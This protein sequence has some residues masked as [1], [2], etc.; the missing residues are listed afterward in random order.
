MHCE[1]YVSIVFNLKMSIVHCSH[2]HRISWWRYR[3]RVLLFRSRKLFFHLFLC[4]CRCFLVSV[5][6]YRTALPTTNKHIWFLFKWPKWLKPQIRYEWME[7]HHNFQRNSQNR[8]KW[9]IQVNCEAT[10]RWVLV[11]LHN[12]VLRSLYFSFPS[13]FTLFFFLLFLFAITISTIAL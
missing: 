4:V 8:L 9:S 13:H 2:S 11:F 7:N 5:Y 3:L 6:S 12:S 1:H 10:M